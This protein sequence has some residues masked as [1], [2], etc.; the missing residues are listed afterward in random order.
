MDK[1]EAM[2]DAFKYLSEIGYST[3][4]NEDYE[5]MVR[6]AKNTQSKLRYKE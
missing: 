4:R 2:N 5:K 3:M 6:D 1:F